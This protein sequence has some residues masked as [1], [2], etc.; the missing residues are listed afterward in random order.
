M[1]SV[2]L[3]TI[4]YIFMNISYMTVLSIP[5]MT[6]V[7]AVAVAF[8]EKVLGN[9]QFVIPLGVALSTFG[10]ALSVQF[11]VTRYFDHFCYLKLFK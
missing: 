9:F 2:P 5:E 3:V 6:S 8:G 7:P 1:I 10:C 4:F 11:G